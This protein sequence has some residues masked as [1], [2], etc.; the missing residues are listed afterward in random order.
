VEGILME[1]KCP[2]RAAMVSHSEKVLKKVEEF[3]DT[4]EHAEGKF[5]EQKEHQHYE[6]AEKLRRSG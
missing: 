3:R 2:V 1:F 5:H 6:R 4:S